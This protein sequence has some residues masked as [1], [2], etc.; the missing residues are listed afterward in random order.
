MYDYSLAC[1]NSQ[2]CMKTFNS[3]FF[4]EIRE[5]VKNA[6]DSID[7][8]QEGYFNDL[9]LTTFVKAMVGSDQE[10]QTK[11]FKKGEDL[12]DA[13]S[14]A[15]MKYMITSDTEQNSLQAL[16]DTLKLTEV[17]NEQNRLVLLFVDAPPKK[18]E[19]IAEIK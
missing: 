3:Y 6:L 14:A 10:I 4:V 5:A 12:V 16:L 19:L 18:P 7:K 1:Q 13:L 9:I 8:K 17:A 2:K 15:N 11:K